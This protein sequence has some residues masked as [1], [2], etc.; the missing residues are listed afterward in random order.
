MSELWPFSSGGKAQL[1]K[2][3]RCQLDLGHWF[4]RWWDDV[5][6]CF[7]GALVAGSRKHVVR[8][9]HSRQD[10]SAPSFV[11]HLVGSDSNLTQAGPSWAWARQHWDDQSRPRTAARLERPWC[12][13]RSRRA[14]WECP[15]RQKV[16]GAAA[17]WWLWF[18]WC[19]QDIVLIED[20][21][22]FIGIIWFYMILFLFTGSKWYWIKID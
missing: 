7:L 17:Q 10:N 21:I 3:S 12:L 18:R 19:L 1:G 4:H 16:M 22:D 13:N 20:F 15:K 6:G 9:K 5:G 14:R 2:E 11:R 8:S